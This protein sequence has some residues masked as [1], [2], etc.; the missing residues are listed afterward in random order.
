M[1]LVS[2]GILGLLGFRVSGLLGFGFQGFSG[3]LPAVYRVS[4]FRVPLRRNISK[5]KR[6]VRP[7]S[8][9]A[10]LKRGVSENRGRVLIVRILLFRVLS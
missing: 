5:Q 7:S 1:G 8:S 2:P 3:I 9:P 6:Q 4:G 10:L